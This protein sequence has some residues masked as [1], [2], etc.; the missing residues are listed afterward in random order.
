MRVFLANWV[1]GCKRAAGINRLKEIGYIA[2]NRA[3]FDEVAGVESSNFTHDE[4]DSFRPAAYRRLAATSS[5]ATLHT[6]THDAYLR[7]PSGE[8]LFPADVSIG[9]I[10]IARNPLDVAISFAHHFDIGIDTAI[11]RMEQDDYALAWKTDREAP[12]LRQT[13]LSWSGH[14]LSWLNQTEMPVHLVRFEDMRHAPEE[15]FSNCLRFLGHTIDPETLRK[16]IAFSSFENLSAQ[17]KQQGFHEKLPQ[18][19]SFF[20]SGKTGQWAHTL[21]Q[22]QIA[23]I[24]EKH[25]AV[26]QRL[27]YIGENGF[28]EQFE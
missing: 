4:I 21:T 28:I 20:R 24:T 17:E 14:V 18:T 25:F 19:K 26:M 8:P 27:G 15:A 16:A 13:L 10:Y 1:G 9:A 12:Q 2:S 22:S 11:E 6:K 5:L 3:R 7:T 23:R